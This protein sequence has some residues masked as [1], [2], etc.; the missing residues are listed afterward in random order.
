MAI[1]D[2][3]N[4]GGRTSRLLVNDLAM[5]LH[6]RTRSVFRR[7]KGGSPAGPLTGIRHGNATW[8]IRE[9][10]REYILAA[11]APD[12]FHVG[13]E[14]HAE[15]VESGWQ[16]AVWR[17]DHD[18][19]QVFA[20]V[21]RETG[22]RNRVKAW[23]FGTH[24][25]REWRMVMSASAAGVPAPAAIGVGVRTANSMDN[26]FLTEAFPNA[27]TLSETWARDVPTA[28]DARRRHAV[29]RLIDVVARLLATGHRRGFAH[30]D[31]HPNNILIAASKDDD[32]EAAFV[33]TH[34]SR[35]GRGP[36]AQRLT[37]RAL[38]HLDQYFHRLATRTERMHFL[39]AYQSYLAPDAVKAEGCLDRRRLVA[40]VH[41]ERRRHAAR[42]AKQRDR[43][44]RGTGS[45]FLR[46]ELGGGWRASVAT[47]LE[48]RHVFPEATV[49]DR[50]AA[51]WREL[52]TS[53]VK[54]GY[55]FERAELRAGNGCVSFEWT[56]VRGLFER[57][58]SIFVASKHRCAFESCHRRRH[59]D[60]YAALVLGYAEHRV[61]GL[62]DATVL[63][64]PASP[65]SR[66]GGLPTE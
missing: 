25:E 38:A 22:L 47:K 28:F 45:Y 57:L 60:L 6:F 29:R 39:R 2:S 42:L 44:I 19:R 12:W 58:R 54:D 50:T 65:E 48:R 33:D 15:C 11:D 36:I 8:I 66:H 13:R 35:L 1:D 53:L 18:G 43:R 16:R 61:A 63:M 20:K 34:G 26:V 46:L 51:Q 21:V 59:R 37:I 40:Q 52:L 17:V 4:G 10:W 7:N 41:A 31:G 5:R 14:P 3:A 49:P 27:V 23:L 62:V 32:L 55:G 9:D 64:R 24:A 56:A 30:R